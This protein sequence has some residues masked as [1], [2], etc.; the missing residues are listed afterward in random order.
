LQEFS[1]PSRSWR[2]LYHWNEEF[3]LFSFDNEAQARGAY[4]KIP[5]LAT[6][7]LSHN[8]TVIE[9]WSGDKNWENRVRKYWKRAVDEGVPKVRAS[10]MVGPAL[11]LIPSNN[12]FL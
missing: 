2:I 9:S 8:E 1:N 7:I 6:R 3:Q 12:F 4:Q 5:K 11:F 10:Y